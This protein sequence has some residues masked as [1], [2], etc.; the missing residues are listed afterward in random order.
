MTPNLLLWLILIATVRYQLPQTA[1][2]ANSGQDNHPTL[3]STQ[4]MTS[5]RLFQVLMAWESAL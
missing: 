3:L 4:L 1:V 5:S 2:S